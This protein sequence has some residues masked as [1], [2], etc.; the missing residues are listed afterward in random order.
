MSAQGRI[1]AGP[2]WQLLRPVR[3]GLKRHLR[4]FVD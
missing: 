4:L 1:L 2:K 3:S